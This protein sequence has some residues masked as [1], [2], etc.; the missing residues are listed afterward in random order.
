MLAQPEAEASRA[1][2]RDSALVALGSAKVVGRAIVIRV[3][4]DVPAGEVHA[5]TGAVAE[6]AAADARPVEGAVEP[7]MPP[8]APVTITQQP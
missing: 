4:D 6:R 7:R 2:F 3:D 1:G 5:C 8:A